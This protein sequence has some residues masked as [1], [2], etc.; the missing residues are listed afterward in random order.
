MPFT[1]QLSSIYSVLSDQIPISFSIK[2]SAQ[3][4]N[5]EEPT[6]RNAND[7]DSDGEE[8]DDDEDE[9]DDEDGQNLGIKNQPWVEFQ[10]DLPERYPDEKPSI[11][12]LESNNLDEDDLSSLMDLLNTEADNSLGNVMIFT[13]VSAGVEWL[14]A[15][16]EVVEEEI[17]TAE[18][19]RNKE[20]IAEE[21]RKIDG[22]PVTKQTFLAWKARFDA[23]MLKLKLD[24]QKKSGDQGSSATGTKGLTGREL[25]ETDKSLIESDLNFVEDLDQNQIE[26]LLQDVE[27]FELDDED[28]DDD[29]DE[30]DDLTETDLED[31]DSDLSLTDDEED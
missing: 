9:D 31:Q 22:T 24:Q 5:Y 10:F 1:N 26:A 2:I 25:F 23:E 19:Q 11:Q 28:D 18:E 7:N 13:L 15:K 3:A 21:Q 4:S 20:R 30:D 17:D 27:E 14:S 6:Y 29:D 12:L 16:T 8:D